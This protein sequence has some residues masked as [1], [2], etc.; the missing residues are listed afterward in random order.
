MSSDRPGWTSTTNSPVSSFRHIRPRPATKNQSSSTLAWRTA[1]ATA[2]GSRRKWAMLPRLDADEQPHLRAVRRDRVGLLADRLFPEARPR[3]AERR[4]G[5]VG[6]GGGERL[7]EDDQRQEEHRHHPEHP[8][9]QRRQDPGLT[10]VM[11]RPLERRLVTRSEVKI[12]TSEM[13][14]VSARA[15][16]MES[17]KISGARMKRADRE[18]GDDDDEAH[19]V[20]QE[21]RAEDPG[22]RRAGRWRWREVP[23]PSKQ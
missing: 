8:D 20:D 21:G 4:P 13:P 15:Y 14:P 5:L 7:L 19:R 22:R 9:D 17:L 11:T 23:A 18:D 10:P 1:R 2:P 3:S 12:T 16:R 6:A